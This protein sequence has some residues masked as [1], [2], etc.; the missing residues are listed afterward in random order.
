MEDHLVQKPHI[1]F[2]DQRRN[3]NLRLWE[4]WTLPDRSL[5]SP[6]EERLSL[7]G[8]L[9]ICRRNVARLQENH[10]IS[11]EN[12]FHGLLVHV[13]AWVDIIELQFQL[14]SL[15]G[16]LLHQLVQCGGH[17]GE[18]VQMHACAETV[19][20]QILKSFGRRI[21]GISVGLQSSVERVREQQKKT[22]RST[23]GITFHT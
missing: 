9:A 22:L 18:L 6:R 3:S 7:L 10:E 4:L 15:Y 14:Q 2:F 17:R 11:G 21:C 8:R 5:C 19:F 12:V 13:G 16:F 23:F 1:L 20:K